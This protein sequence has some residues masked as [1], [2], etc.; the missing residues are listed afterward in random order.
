[1][2]A[3]ARNVNIER[4]GMPYTVRIVDFFVDTYGYFTGYFWV[5]LNFVTYLVPLDPFLVLPRSVHRAAKCP[6]ALQGDAGLAVP[7]LGAHGYVCNT[8]HKGYQGHFH[9]K[10]TET[11]LNQS[12]FNE[13]CEF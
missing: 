9:A 11:V 10:N 2:A 5:F 4:I 6:S 8:G 3:Q 12:M 1:M 7:A 13:N